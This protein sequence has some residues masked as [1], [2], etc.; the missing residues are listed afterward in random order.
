MVV[1]VFDVL[2]KAGADVDRKSD[3]HSRTPLH[4]LCAR[5]DRNS[6]LLPHY[7]DKRTSYFDSTDVLVKK[8]Q[9]LLEYNC[10][11]NCHDAVGAIELKSH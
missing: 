3:Y 9:M 8:A 11:I 2:L 1:Q 10:D 4:Y 6:T 7:K 5:P